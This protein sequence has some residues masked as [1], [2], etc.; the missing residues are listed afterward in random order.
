MVNCIAGSYE[1]ASLGGLTDCS[2]TPAWV[3]GLLERFAEEAGRRIGNF[4]S[5]ISG[6]HPDMGSP[7]RRVP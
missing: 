1:L 2:L 5:I 7:R 4:P 6:A 3:W